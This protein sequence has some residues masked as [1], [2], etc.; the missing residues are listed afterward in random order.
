MVTK[1]DDQV[2]TGSDS[3]VATIRGYRPGDKVTLTVATGS[4]THSVKVTLDSDEGSA[5]S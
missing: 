1:V 5:S 3:L 2:V 4:Q